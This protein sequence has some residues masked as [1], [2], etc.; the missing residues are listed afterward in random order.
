[1]DPL[2]QTTP[3]V[4]LVEWDGIAPL[5]KLTD[6][7]LTPEAARKFWLFSPAVRDFEVGACTPEQFGERVVQ[8]LRLDCSPAEFLRQFESW[9]R[10]PLPGTAELLEKLK[11][12]VTLACLSNNN[13]LHWRRLSTYPRF[14]ECF[15]HRFVSFQIGKIKPDADVFTHVLAQL[16]VP[17]DEVLFFDDNVE[18][19]DMAV[20]AG[21]QAR[22]TRGLEPVRQTLKEL[23]L[24]DEPAPG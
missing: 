12:R 8:E 19:V 9:D 1:M 21:M 10:G 2:T 15:P 23:G 17:P 20:R 14:L 11:D 22:L 16:G 18:C 4:L 13:E 3:K 6:G 7:Q 5:L 24:L